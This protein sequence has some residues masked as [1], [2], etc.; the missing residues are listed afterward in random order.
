MRLLIGL[1]LL[2]TSIPVAAVGARA[3][4]GE[5]AAKRETVSTRSYWRYHWTFRPARFLSTKGELVATPTRYAA[6]NTVATGNQLATPLPPEGWTKA[7]FDDSGWAVSRAP[8]PIM[9]DIDQDGA[10]PYSNHII[11]VF[12]GRTR[13][14]VPD[15]AQ[16]GTVKLE[17]SYY[18]GLIVYVNG[19]EVARGHIPVKEPLK[20]E[21]H[22]EPYPPDAYR[23]VSKEQRSWGLTHQGWWSA[24]LWH[25]WRLKGEAKVRAAKIRSIRERRLSVNVPHKLLRKGVNVLAVENRL[26]PFIEFKTRRRGRT[27][28]PKNAHRWPHVGIS[29]VSLETDAPGS[30]RS[31]DQRSPGVRVWVEDIHRWMLEEDFLEPG[32]KQ[33]RTIDMVGARG[34]S[35]SGQVIIGTS[36]KLSAPAAKISGLS[37]PDGAKIPASA[38]RIRWARSLSVTLIK[39]TNPGAFRTYMQDLFLIRYRKAPAN[40]WPI[41]WSGPSSIGRL[42]SDAWARKAMRICD[43]LSPQAPAE[44]AAGKSQPIW[45]TV[46]IPEGTKP[47]KYKGKLT[48][49]AGGMPEASLDVRLEVVDWTLPKPTNYR[50]YVGIDQS[51]WALA[52]WNK[53]KLWSP[54]HWK[55]M[56]ESIRWAGQLGARVVGI[57]VIRRTELSNGD[58]TMIKWVRKPDGSYSYDFSLADRYIELWKKHCRT[59]S[60]IIVYLVHPSDVYGRGGGTGTVTLADGT[61]FTPPQPDTPEGRKLWVHCARAIRKHF[62]ARGVSDRNLHWGFFYDHSGSRIKS[63]ALALNTATPSVGWARSCHTGANPFHNNEGRIS[64]HAAVR[65]YQSP[66]FFLPRKKGA[67]RHHYDPSAGYKVKSHRG[68]S[69]PDALLL[70]P[71]ADSDV[72]AL[73]MHPPL[74]Q[75]RALM[76]MP[77][78]SKH[79]G[80]ARISVDGWGRGGY[81]GPFNPYLLYPGAP[82]KMDGSVQFEILREGLQECETR[83]A[84]VERNVPLPAVRKLLDRRTERAW[85]LPPRPEGQRISEFHGGWRT[86]SRELYRAAAAEFKRKPP[87]VG[88]LSRNLKSTDKDTRARAAW[89]LGV[90]GPRGAKASADLV[91]ALSDAEEEV[92]TQA[93]RTL[94]KLGASAAPTLAKALSASDPRARAAAAKALASLGPRAGST[95]SDLA[96]AL[97]DKDTAVRREAATALGSI[98]P[99]A[100]KSTPVLVAGL[101]DKD[102]GVRSRAAAALGWIGPAAKASVPALAAAL[103]D[104][105][106]GVRRSAAEALLKIGSEASGAVSELV[107]ALKDKDKRVRAAAA[108]ALGGIGPGAIKALKPLCDATKDNYYLVRM[109]AIIS[110]GKFGPA[111]KEAIPMLEELAKKRDY[112]ARAALKNIRR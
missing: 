71:R 89:S 23:P 4:A 90:I 7:D 112:H 56:E 57:P 99:D 106:G 102:E 48:V 105:K 58:D 79:R 100:V 45:L 96:K 5:E 97:K 80:F 14:L 16:T 10:G 51:P 24:G 36:R 68:W 43:Q 65:C 15:P 98:G 27:T 19:T 2:L 3:Q 31:A 47:G 44:I 42:I 108:A 49:R 13:F 110:L 91:A 25:D 101:K 75:L 33:R 64:W 46:Q 73:S 60:D 41:Y 21:L 17:L 92:R 66:P 62:N 9:P 87:T 84:I 8:L 54:Q 77:I 52:K 29:R 67:P 103:K 59:D 63:F 26:S 53:V 82:G 6:L 30:L 107:V 109:N 94:S 39:K 78:T 72:T 34:G 22:A 1:L 38:I 86:L 104:E 111:A 81:F 95:T 74:Y 11:R 55:L 69:N 85:I 37:G 12:S 76:E 50:A 20:T 18:G 88:D 40:T 83:I 32:V 70:L 61:A 35:Y 28:L 93:A